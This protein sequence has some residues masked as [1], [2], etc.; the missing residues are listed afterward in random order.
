MAKKRLIASPARGLSVIL[1]P[2][3]RRLGCLPAE[4]FVRALMEHL[5]QPNCAAR[6]SAAQFHGVA[7]FRPRVF[8]FAVTKN[9]RAI[10]CGAIR[11]AFVA[12]KRITDVSVQRINTS[13]I[14]VS[15]P[16]ATVIDLV[17]Y[18]KWAAGLDNVATIL[19]ELA[20][21]LGVH[22]I[23]G[24]TRLL[25]PALLRDDAEQAQTLHRKRRK[26]RERS[27]CREGAK[28]DESAL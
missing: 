9:R 2:E 5:G 25:Q 21:C 11:I 8:Q 26:E 20:E 10:T 4:L 17:G 6:L 28:P 19:T 12:R 27:H 15:T 13:T 16:Q 24:S 7:H 14:L 3:Y 23:F 22:P 18:A 1:C